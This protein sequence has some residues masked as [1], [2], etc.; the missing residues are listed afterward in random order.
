[1]LTYTP[2]QLNEIFDRFSRLAVMVIGDV[3]IDSYLWG[4]VNRISPEAPVPIVN[5]NKRDNRL[6]GAANVALNLKALGAEPYLCAVVGND[7][8]AELFKSL[9]AE[10]DL[11]QDG[12]L[13][14]DHRITTTKF[15][16]I[17]NNTQMLRV[18]EEI[19]TPLGNDDAGLF[20]NRL[21]SIIQQRRIDAIIF[22]DYDK[23]VITPELIAE[24]VEIA[25]KKNIPVVVDPKKRNFH[26]YKNVT[27]FKPNLKEITE[28]L[29]SSPEVFDIESLQRMVRALHSKQQI[30]V[31]M[32]TLSEHGVFISRR[33]NDQLTEDHHIPA[34]FRT[35]ADVSGAGDTVVSVATLTLAAGLNDYE[36]A[37]VS[38]LAGGQV[39]E[40]VGVAPVDA[41]KLK[42]EMISRK[43]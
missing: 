6:G 7:D 19:D 30:E 4:K 10:N 32:V 43:L 24:I 20:L 8:K 14:S 1:M 27:L 28:G 9:L 15:R 12:I 2:K 3:M 42:N 17:G 34:H 26:N 18:D 13:K 37:A 39:C 25:G 36:I 31:V 33:I 38:N 29:G 16:V 11:V 22:Q 23:G 5:V 21:R 35:I 41:Q 40:F